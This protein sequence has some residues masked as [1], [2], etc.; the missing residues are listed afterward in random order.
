MVAARNPANI[1]G[2]P[3]WLLRGGIL[4]ALVAGGYLVFELGRI[5]ASYSIVDSFVERQVFHEEITGLEA[6][7]IGLN[8]EVT[9]LETHRD[10]DREAYRDVEVNLTELQRKIQ[11]QSDAIAFYR[12]IVSPADGGRGL[13]VQNLKLKK[14]KEE[15]S[16]IVRL[17]LIQVMQH[18]RSVKGNVNFS[19]E[20]EQDGVATTYTLQQLVP[21]DEDSNW[22]FSFRYFQDFDRKVVLPDGFTPERINIEVKSRTKSIASIEQ[23]F[24]WQ[25]GQS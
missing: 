3:V 11:E 25:T 4:L 21:P 19:I 20:G 9:L 16:Y 1:S 15:R 13:R 8:E 18:D 14:G 6:Q 24:L 5:Q 12:G 17:V 10:I 7:I 23:S 22:P 2:I